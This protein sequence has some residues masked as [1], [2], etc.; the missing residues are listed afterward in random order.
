MTSP[1]NAG[2]NHV[3]TAAGSGIEPKNEEKPGKWGAGYDFLV[4]HLLARESR[5]EVGD[6]LRLSRT[7]FGQ[8]HW[9]GL[10]SGR[11]RKTNRSQPLVPYQS[12]N[13]AGTPVRKTK[14]SG[15]QT[16]NFHKF[17]P[18]NHGI[19]GTT[20]IAP[21]NTPNHCKTAVPTH[22]NPPVR[23]AP[24]QPPISPKPQQPKTGHGF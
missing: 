20:P 2:L 12:A 16:A 21:G 7:L 19:D 18:A 13:S 3:G 11:T 9:R 6:R 5:G 14:R 17:A 8:P 23:A 1:R 24:P 15:T 22:P 4:K 10:I